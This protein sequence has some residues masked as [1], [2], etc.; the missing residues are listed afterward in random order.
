MSDHTPLIDGHCPR[1]F[2]E[3][4]EAREAYDAARHD[5]LG[6]HL[7]QIHG[8]KPHPYRRGQDVYNL[9]MCEAIHAHIHRSKDP[10]DEQG[11]PWDDHEPDDLS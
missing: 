10:D 4:Q 3:A 5:A 8:I 9:A 6:E 7:Y 1:C 2:E 11:Q